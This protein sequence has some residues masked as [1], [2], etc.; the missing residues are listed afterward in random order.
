[1]TAR[2]WK[3][4]VAQSRPLTDGVSGPVFTFLK[5]GVPTFFIGSDEPHLVT[6]LVGP[7]ETADELRA[8]WA[9]EGRAA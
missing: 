5:D 3:Q 8:R 1:M 2:T 6:L 7:G 4:A 9:R